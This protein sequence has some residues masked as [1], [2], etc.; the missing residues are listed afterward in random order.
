MNSIFYMM[1]VLIPGKKLSSFIWLKFL[2]LFFSS[3]P[4]RPPK[5]NP[6][7][8][9]DDYSEDK[10]LLLQSNQLS[11]FNPSA[12]TSTLPNLYFS[13]NTRTTSSSKSEQFLDSCQNRS[14]YQ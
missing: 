5:R 4:G 10:R 7:H 3:R 13:N 14:E 9:I 8:Q 12:F 11:L 1:I 2:L 6:S